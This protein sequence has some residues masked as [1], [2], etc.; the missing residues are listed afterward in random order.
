[1]LVLACLGL[2]AGEVPGLT[3]QDL[4]WRKW[5]GGQQLGIPARIDL[6][7]PLFTRAD[8][9]GSQHGSL[10]QGARLLVKFDGANSRYPLE[11]A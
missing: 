5:I 1:M 7:N 8:I 11:D 4:D 6:G 9:K 10:V 3:L 2:R